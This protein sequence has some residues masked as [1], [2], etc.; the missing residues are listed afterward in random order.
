[1]TK[2]VEPT[3]AD[4]RSAKVLGR[5][6]REVRRKQGLSRSE[7]AR[8]A[9]LTRHELATYE[10]GRSAIP[11]SDLWCLA[12]SCGVGMNEILPEREPLRVSSGLS[13][14]A[15]GDTIRRL[16]APG[17]PDGILCEYLSMIYTLRSL[18]P[19]S[20]VPFR[21]PDL[22]ALADALGGRPDAIEA[23]LVELIGA[24]HEEAARLRAM[25]LPRL[26]L[27]AAPTAGEQGPS[28][29]LAARNPEA[30]V[31]D[32]FSAPR[33][34]DPFSPQPSP[35]APSMEWMPEPSMAQAPTRDVFDFPQD[36]SGARDTIA[37]EMPGW[38]PTTGDPV[39]GGNGTT[40]LDPVV[41]PFFVPAAL[42]AEPM[43][44]IL[45]I[46]WHAPV[47]PELPVDRAPLDRDVAESASRFEPADKTWRVGGLFPATLMADDGALSLRRTDVRW[48]LSNLEASGDVTVE[49]VLDYTAG[50]GFGVLFRADV[51]DR[52]RVSGYSFDI[53]PVAGGGYLVR[54]WA[55]NRPHWRPIVQAPVTDPAH[56]FGRHTITVALQGD[57]LTALV[58]GETVLEVPALS[59][60][61]IDLG[62]EPCRG[63]NL[64]VHGGTSTELTIESFHA[65]QPR[66]PTTR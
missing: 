23:R 49:A 39:P 21:E 53:N 63:S 7:V 50:A 52:G 30:A 11:E 10:R 45:P 55:C 4:A 13:S 36:D 28:D 33:A 64:G 3:E 34:P 22:V 29:F 46:A 9:G 2:T 15:M 54:Q 56:L 16:R 60:S 59:R 5:H 19:G 65:A 32:F 8:S 51:D 20:R 66:V 17:Q 47:E 41:E 18:P 37:V 38:S 40:A 44:A 25:I 48:A 12:G 35:D 58:D 62:R 31:V 27:P 1:M 6:L 61:S 42:L 14:L 26:S 43:P 24:S 57:R